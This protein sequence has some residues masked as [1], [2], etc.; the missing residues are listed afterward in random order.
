MAMFCHYAVN[1]SFSLADGIA[2]LYR[3]YDST[4]EQGPIQMVSAFHALN[5]MISVRRGSGLLLDWR[6]SGGSLLAGGDSR[7]IRHWDAHTESQTLVR[8]TAARTPDT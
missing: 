3:N 7:I 4:L 2:R 8:S 1:K 6:Q 5:E